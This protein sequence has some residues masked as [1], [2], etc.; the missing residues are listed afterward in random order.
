MLLNTAEEWTVFNQANDKAHPFHIH[1]NPFQIIE[2]FE[3]N[4]PEATDKS[5]PACHADPAKPE[6]WKPCEKYL[7]RIK[8]QSPWVWW[9]TFAIP[10]ARNETFDCAGDPPNALS[11]RAERATR[12]ARES[13]SVR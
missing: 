3:P 13:S 1:I 7:R 11:P 2:L 4:S 8:L 12:I 10:T 5:D 6:T 9:D